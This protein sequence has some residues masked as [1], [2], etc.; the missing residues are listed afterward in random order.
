MLSA[1]YFC[2]I[3]TTS[4]FARQTFVNVPISHSTKIRPVRAAL[5][6]AIDRQT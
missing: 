4:V 6:H 5:I 1:Q 3:L 2:S